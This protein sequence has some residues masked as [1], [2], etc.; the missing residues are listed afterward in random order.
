MK[1]YATVYKVSLICATTALSIVTVLTLLQADK[2]ILMVST[3]L[4]Y[5]AVIVATIFY[6]FTKN[7]LPISKSFWYKLYRSLNVV[8]TISAIIVIGMIAL[9]YDIF[10]IGLLVLL[11]LPPNIF[12]YFYKKNSYKSKN[13]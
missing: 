1:Y 10:S 6:P 9:K 3:A 8:T 2:V 12:I 4:I 7:R 11:Q 13:F 5:V